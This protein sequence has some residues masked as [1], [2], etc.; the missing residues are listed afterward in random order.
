[1]GRLLKR[2]DCRAGGTDA[3]ACSYPVPRGFSITFPEFRKRGKCMVG[4]CRQGDTFTARLSLLICQKLGLIQG[5]S[6]FSAA[7]GGRW[8]FRAT[9]PSGRFP[10]LSITFNTKEKS[11]VS[12]INALQARRWSLAFIQP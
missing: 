6:C 2:P 8:T 3:T 10:P 1:M 5:K 9:P 4:V 11:A 12:R 7:N